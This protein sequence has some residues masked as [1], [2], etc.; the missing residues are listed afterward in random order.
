MSMASTESTASAVRQR[1]TL[2]FGGRRLGL[3]AHRGRKPGGV[4]GRYHPHRHYTLSHSPGGWAGAAFSDPADGEGRGTLRWRLRFVMPAIRGGMPGALVPG[5][6][7]LL[8]EAPRSP[9]GA[10]PQPPVTGGKNATSSP[11]WIGES[12]STTS[13]LIEI[14]TLWSATK[15]EARARSVPAACRPSPPPV[16]T[17]WW[18]RRSPRM[19]SGETVVRT[20]RWSYPAG[21]AA[22]AEPQYSGKP[23]SARRARA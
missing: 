22:P 7:R 23:G 19:R 16:G 14:W 5:L 10:I 21:A 13:W 20:T 1:R 3:W 2:L 18:R 6:C 9:V 8:A 11:S 4:G 12:A 15:T 17:G